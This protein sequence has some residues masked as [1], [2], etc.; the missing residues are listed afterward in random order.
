MEKDATWGKF[1]HSVVGA[2]S[3]GSVREAMGKLQAH[4][5]MVKVEE[6]SPEVETVSCEMRPAN[7]EGEDRFPEEIKKHKENRLFR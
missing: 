6:W 1:V 2:A 4:R 5:R 7:Q 3:Y